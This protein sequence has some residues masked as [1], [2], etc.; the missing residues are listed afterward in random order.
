MK[1]LLLILT[2]A[3]SLGLAGCLPNTDDPD[4]DEYTTAYTEE[5]LI[6]LIESLIPEA[7]VDT[8]YDI[9]SFQEAI[10]NVID[11]ARGGVLGLQVSTALGTGTGSGVIYKH[12]G[13]YYYMVTNEHVVVDYLTVTVVYEKNGLLF[14]IGNSNVEVLGMDEVTD[15]AV[16]RFESDEDFNVISFADSYDIY[17]GQFVFAIGNP[18]GFDYYGTVTM[19]V[20][21]GTARYVQ[22][23]VFDAT[24]I[25]HDA[26]ISPG[27]SGGALIDLNGE[28]L[29]I[30]N[31][32]LVDQDV[33]NIGFAIP[34]NTVQRIINDLED[35]G[36]VTRPYLGITTYSQINECGLDSGV[37]VYVQNG[38]AAQ[39]AGLLD[40]DVIIGWKNIT[41]GMTEY[42][43]IKNF[44]DLRE[45][46]LN[47]SVGDTI[48][49]QYVRDGIE[50]ESVETTLDVHPDDQ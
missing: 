34:S 31:L 39:A 49:L 38:G 5:E 37:C 45:A 22:S 21:S 42:L 3:L 36:E 32:K 48:V 16:L 30:N 17:P 12:E 4:P 50:Y 46:I 35:D 20:I 28:L 19:G 47:S 24:L 2:L 29:G 43:E 11:E 9:A 18:L 13:G 33:S 27:N 7:Q 40:F 44:N 6:E 41:V 26:A 10:K 23:G 14:E 1:K 8:T 25:Q 15:L